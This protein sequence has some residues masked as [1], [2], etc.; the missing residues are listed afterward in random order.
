MKKKKKKYNSGSASPARV[1]TMTHKLTNEFS[2]WFQTS[3]HLFT[4]LNEGYLY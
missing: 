1:R 2:F 4:C 3:K